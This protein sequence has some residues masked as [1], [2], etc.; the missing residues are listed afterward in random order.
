IMELTGT[1]FTYHE[2]LTAFESGPVNYKKAVI[3]IGGITELFNA[4][5][6]LAPLQERL[7]KLGWTLVQVQ[8]SSSGNGYGTS[9][10][11]QDSKELD[12]LVKYLKTKRNKEKIVFL[13]HS[14][15]KKKGEENSY[16]HN[17]YGEMSVNGYILQAPISDRLVM[18]SSDPTRYTKLLQDAKQ[19]IKEGRSEELMPRQPYLAPITAYRFASLVD[20]R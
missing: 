16:W 3:Y 18:M 8:L 1:L 12:Y 10:L 17:K 5:S 2:A 20:Y 15:G 9:S 14:T 4:V 11:R 13:G 7:Y 19:M 6:Y